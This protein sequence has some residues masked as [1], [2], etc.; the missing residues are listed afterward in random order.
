MLY[1]LFDIFTIIV[2]IFFVRNA[3]KSLG[4]GTKS[5]Y[6]I[7]FWLLYTLP[8]YLDYLVGIPNYQNYGFIVSSHDSI[9]R[10]IYDIGLLVAFLLINRYNKRKT[11]ADMGNVKIPYWLFI[12]G[13]FICPIESYLVMGN[14]WNL[15]IIFWR[16]NEVLDM[17]NLP[18]DFYL[19]EAFSYFGIACS[20]LLLFEDNRN[21]AYPKLIKSFAI[22]LLYI[23]VSAEGKRAALFFALLVIS[24]IMIYKFTIRDTLTKK[25]LL[26]SSSLKIKILFAIFLV[27]SVMVM[28]TVTE[29]VKV[30]R[31]AR[32]E[33]R[34]LLITSS[35]IDF[36]RDDRV[37][38]S[39]FSE[40]NP[41]Q[42]TILDNVGKTLFEAHKYF[43]P[44]SMITC[45][46]FDTSD[47]NYQQ[48]FTAALDHEGVAGTRGYMTVSIY[49][50]LI[51]NFG[52][53]VG[54]F[55][56][57]LLIILLINISDKLRY[58]LNLLVL[59]NFIF[60]NL[61]DISYCAWMMELSILLIISANLRKRTKSRYYGKIS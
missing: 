53:I 5:L 45:R 47:Y 7:T 42:M 43:F 40:V 32:Y 51:S 6:I 20:C 2:S 38:M 16:E 35:R 57:P 37:R 44:T 1:Q 19:V 29:V 41:D 23:N 55:S 56:F 58:P 24:F 46:I 30:N 27:L 12:M 25:S 50:E 8:L 4:K 60:T 14:I 34:D 36:F 48:Y 28:S 9:S 10:I 3:F 21:M 11:Y 13:C 52:L 39:I 33:D 49:A 18:P 61:F 31:G 15:F 22:V 54:L 17:I 26:E 59:I